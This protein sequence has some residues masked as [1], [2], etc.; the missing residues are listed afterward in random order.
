MSGD[1]DARKTL[2]L[3]DDDEDALEQLSL[4]LGADGYDVRTATGQKDAEEMLLSVRPD[5]AIVDLMM[6]H[7]DSGLVLCHRLKQL[8]PE[9]P[10]IMLTAVTAAT[11]LSLK[12]A[13]SE[14]QSWLTADAIM[15]KPVRPEQIREEIR[16]LLKTPAD[17]ADEHVR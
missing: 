17:V 9:L 11:G 1:M 2:L 4:V 5:L 3:V 16:R 15:D 8:Y 12:P 10:V 7:M 13:T 14:A 6:E